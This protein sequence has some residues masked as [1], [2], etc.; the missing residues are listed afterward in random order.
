MRSTSVVSRYADQV[1]CKIKW[2]TIV[3]KSDYPVEPDTALRGPRWTRMKD[4]R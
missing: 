4:E 3:F 1:D 2:G